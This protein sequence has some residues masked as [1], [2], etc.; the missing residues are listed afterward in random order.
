MLVHCALRYGL[1]DVPVLDDLAVLQA[2]EVSYGSAAVFGRSLQQAVQR[3]QVAL[4]DGALDVV[5][6]LRELLQKA[7]YELNEGLKPVGGLG[8]VLDVVR[9]AV[10]LYGL[11]GL[12]LVEGHVEEGEHRLLVL[13]GVG[14]ENPPLCDPFRREYDATVRGQVRTS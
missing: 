7:F 10:V 12:I 11:G 2:E 4:S 5:A 1:Q 6:Q 3:N 13:F 14:H 9:S 8:V